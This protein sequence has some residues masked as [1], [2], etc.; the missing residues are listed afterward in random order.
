MIM[1]TTTLAIASRITTQARAA[2]PKMKKSPIV[3]S[4]S[5]LLHQDRIR[6]AIAIALTLLLAGSVA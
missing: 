1:T 3:M 2:T 5:P 6:I 4:E